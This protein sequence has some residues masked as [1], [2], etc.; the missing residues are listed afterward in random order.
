[1][2]NAVSSGMFTFSGVSL[3][4]LWLSWSF[5]VEKSALHRMPMPSSF[6]TNITSQDGI[7]NGISYFQQ[8]FAHGDEW[9]FSKVFSTLYVGVF[10]LP[11]KRQ[12]Q[13]IRSSAKQVHKVR[14]RGA[15]EGCTCACFVLCFR[16]S[17][18][19]S[20]TRAYP[21]S[22]KNNVV[23]ND[24]LLMI[25]SPFEKH[26]TWFSHSVIYV[27]SGCDTKL[28]VN[29][30]ALAYLHEIDALVHGVVRKRAEEPEALPLR[31][32]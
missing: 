26:C 21:T 2:R 15:G 8:F 5:F 30:D 6:K 18:Y 31:L 1:M 27:Q 11:D 32:K 19:L 28:R 23:S 4:K 24:P 17:L 3:L 22:I 13:R 14:S 16:M 25:A 12:V 9:D 29:A 20:E 10:V 7:S